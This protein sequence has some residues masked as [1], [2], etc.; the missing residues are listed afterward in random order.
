[1]NSTTG[2]HMRP[3]PRS[4]RHPAEH[5]RVDV[6]RDDFE[7]DRRSA[8]AARL[9]AGDVAAQRS[10][11]IARATLRA[12]I[13]RDG[14]LASARHARFELD[15]A[16]VDATTCT[17]TATHVSSRRSFGEHGRRSTSADLEQA[18]SG[19]AFRS[20]SPRSPNNDESSPP[21]KNTSPASTPPRLDL[22]AARRLDA[23]GHARQRRRHRCAALSD[24]T[25]HRRRTS[26]PSV[27]RWLDADV[28]RAATPMRP[29]RAERSEGDVSLDD[30]TRPSTIDARRRLAR[31]RAG[32]RLAFDDGDVLIDRVDA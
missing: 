7:P 14:S 28:R 18:G 32:H 20:R 13:W 21:S 15:S 30:W 3:M 29:P 2:P 24:W 27:D 31:L 5:R 19:E 25:H 11:S 17:G 6:R 1:M 10:A 8:R 23:A 9:D 4:Q 22:G 26:S 16:G 12:A